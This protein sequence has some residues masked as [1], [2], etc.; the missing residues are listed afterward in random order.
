[1]D[2]FC[3][4][5][6]RAVH[7][8]HICYAA[9]LTKIHRTCIRDGKATR[10]LKVLLADERNLAAAAFICHGSHHAASQ[11]YRL[12]MLPDSAFEFAAEVMG[13]ERAHD[14]LARRYGGED[15]RLDALLAIEAVA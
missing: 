10:P 4:C 12:W 8:H 3:G 7:L 5:C 9:E 15:P 1:M 2:C 13:A 14:W 6:D 11:R